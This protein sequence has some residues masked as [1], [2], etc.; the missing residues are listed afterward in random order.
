[1]EWTIQ[2]VTPDLPTAPQTPYTKDMNKQL[3]QQ[4]INTLMSDYAKQYSAM[5]ARSAANVA[6]F[7]EG[8]PQPYQAAATEIINISD[9]D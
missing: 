3:T 1:V 5:M 7:H 6:A 2:I 4:H 9:R 8:R